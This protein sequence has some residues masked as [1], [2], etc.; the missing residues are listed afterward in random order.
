MRYLIHTC[1]Q[2]EWYVNKYLI[3]SLI[4]QGIQSEDI[5][6]WLDTENKGNL[7]SCMESF[8]YCGKES[9]ATWHLQDDVILCRDFAERTKKFDE[10]FIICGFCGVEVGPCIS[11]IGRVRPTQMWW[12]FQCIQIPNDLAKECSE[13][14]YEDAVFRDNEEIAKRIAGGKSDDWMF[15]RFINEN[16]PN[17]VIINYEPNLVDHIDYLLGGSVINSAR[18]RKHTSAYFK[19]RDLIQILEERL[20]AEGDL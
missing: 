16:Y 10:D 9:G 1:N 2:R 12:S 13:W 19:D 18:T 4:D 11:R 5:M 17:T 15:R 6:V 3:P 14:F 7:H 8:S 20:R